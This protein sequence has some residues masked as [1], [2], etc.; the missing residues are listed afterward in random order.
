MKTLLFALVLLSSV[1]AFAE[2]YFGST[3]TGEIC[4][5]SVEDICMGELEVKV[6]GTAAKNGYI[7]KK[8][9]PELLY[10]SY[11]VEGNQDLQ[12]Q[13]AEDITIEMKDNRPVSYT[14]EKSK[15]TVRPGTFSFLTSKKE[16]Y[17]TIKCTF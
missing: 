11:S 1:S 12:Y 7:V 9:K 8:D 3:E 17:P 10:R 13:T 2:T 5:I 15:T 14:R 4:T 16:V 6:P